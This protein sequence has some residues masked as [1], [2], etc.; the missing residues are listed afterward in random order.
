MVREGAAGLVPALVVLAALVPA[1]PARADTCTVGDAAC[2]TLAEALQAA[3]TRPGGDRVRL[4]AGELDGDDAAYASA[5]A[6]DLVGDGAGATFVTG[7]LSVAGERV[8]IRDLTLRAGAPVVLEAAGRVRSIRVTGEAKDGVAIRALPDT[9]LELDDVAIDATGTGAALE[10]RC[11]TLRARH[12]TVAG[13]GAVGARAGCAQEGGS[14]TLALD[15]SI[16]TRGYP[17]A[18]DELPRGAV[19]AA[20][21]NLAGTTEGQVFEPVPGEPMFLS[22]GDLRL[23]PDSPLIERGNPA[24][25]AVD[26]PAPGAPDASEPIE[27]LEGAV[28]IA[29]GDSDG[30]ARRDVGAYEAPPRA[31]FGVPP[32]N[33][34]TNPDA[35][36]AGPGPP[37]GWALTGGFT[38]VDYGTPLYPN[39]RTGVALGGGAAFFF[40]DG[41]GRPP[42]GGAPGDATA[43]QVVDV[44]GR[45]AAIDA[46]AGR[47]TLSGLLG[48]YRADGD[49]LGARAT[50]RGPS[51]ITLGMLELDPVDAAARGNATNLLP[52]SATA[53]VPAL[54]RSIEV[55]LSASKAPGG[56]FTD[57]YFD[58]LGLTLQLPTP[59]GDDPP[60]D[61]DDPRGDGPRPFAGILV[62]SGE[63]VLSKRTRRAKVLVGCA[64]AT[65]ARCTGDLTLQAILVRRAPREVIGRARVSLAPGE[66]RRVAVRFT[67]AARAYVRRHT[68]LRV[69]VGTSAVD[70]QGVRRATTVPISVR[71]QRGGRRR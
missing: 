5:D 17:R 22:A 54:T 20:Y 44:S 13:D 49:R 8:T 35:E 25:L 11:A 57:A 40:A 48:G 64:S 12:V 69:R 9:P 67:R 31:P 6:L 56:S 23:A 24:P 59:P 62:L 3:E 4:P 68:R 66:A 29:D 2:P 30:R 26:H 53:S 58:N 46:G 18:L 60:G 39:A 65:V 45:A 33:L 43:T 19:S 1:A 71:P 34:L 10:A 63:S 50:F 70:G 27:D 42:D 7:H 47:A 51:G 61:D 15:S 32:G 28:R 55:R 41:T 21:S 38:T 16:V 37:P 36:S 52:R 14:A